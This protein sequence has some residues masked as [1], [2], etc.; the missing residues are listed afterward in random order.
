[1]IVD[2]GETKRIVVEW[3]HEM[4]W[5]IEL[6]CL[7]EAKGVSGMIEKTWFAAKERRKPDLDTPTWFAF[8]PVLSSELR[9]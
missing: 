3:P 5:R 7:R 9:E 4:P 6:T 8:G 2:P 1:V